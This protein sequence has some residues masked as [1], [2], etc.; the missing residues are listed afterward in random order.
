MIGTLMRFF[1]GYDRLACPAGSATPLLDLLLRSAI[2]YF[3]LQT[4]EDDSCTFAVLRKDLPALQKLCEGK[5]D[6]CLTRRLGLPAIVLR[7]RRRVGILL[8]ALIF[9]FGVLLASR[10]VWRIDIYGNETIPDADVLAELSEVGFGIGTYLPRVNFDD[11][12]NHFLLKSER[13]S[14]ISINMTGTCARVELREMLRGETEETT[15]YANIVAGSDGQIEEVR[16]FAGKRAVAIGDVVKKGDVLISGVIDS[17]LLGARYTHAKGSVYA[18]VSDRITVEIP[19][20]QTVKRETGEKEV[21]K[22]VN[23][24]GKTI[25]FFVNSGISLSTYDKI[26]EEKD[27]LLFDTFVLPIC[28]HTET[29]AG[30]EETTETI[31]AAEAAEM[32]A[33][34]MNRRVKERLTDAVLLEKTVTSRLAEDRYVLECE[35]YLIE[36]IAVS[37]PFEVEAAP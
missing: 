24:F 22:S 23:I 5:I 20:A 27:V 30:Y 21:K 37:V 11:L 19:L 18:R 31:T 34:E 1:A 6:L 29:Y 16:A 36:D 35:L 7:Y 14:W 32:A 15:G 8:G 3:D 10:V 2:P 28:V 13:F 9:C 33:G 4:S 26:V 17:K 25:N 12:H